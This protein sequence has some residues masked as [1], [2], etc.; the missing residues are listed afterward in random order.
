MAV[1]YAWVEGVV[2]EPLAREAYPLEVAWRRSGP[3]FALPDGRA[4]DRA[5]GAL[6]VFEGG[7]ARVFVTPLP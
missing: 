6:L 2:C 5:A 3:A 1:V 4:A 7:S